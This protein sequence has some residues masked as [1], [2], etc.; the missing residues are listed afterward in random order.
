MISVKTNILA[1][2]FNYQEISQLQ[3]EISKH[4]L[5]FNFDFAISVR[6][7]WFSH[8]LVD[9]D[10]ILVDLTSSEKET[11]DVLQEIYKYGDGIS[12]IVIVN[13][14]ELSKISNSFSINPHHFIVKD[15]NYVVKVVSLIKKGADD[16]K[17]SKESDV[18]RNRRMHPLFQTFMNAVHDRVMII[19]MDYRIKV[20]N[21]AVLEKYHCSVYEIVGKKCYEFAYNYDKPC[22]TRNLPCP[23]IQI[24]SKGQSC[25]VMH[26]FIKPDNNN[27][28]LL[29]ISAF[30]L[31]NEFNSTIEIL[32]AVHEENLN[33]KMNAFDHRILTKLI[34]GISE[35]IVF[36]NSQ[37]KVV[38]VNQAAKRLL[39][40][41]SDNWAGMSI[42]EMP[43]G[44]GH[45]W[46][47]YI[48]QNLNSNFIISSPVKIQLKD[49]WLLLRYMPLTDSQNDYLGGFL[50]ITD[51]SLNQTFTET[52][53]GIDPDILSISKFFS[54]KIIAEG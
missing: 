35:G 21:Q 42:F 13:A 15:E 51:L 44:E 52:Q 7:S 6:D 33:Q 41:E 37:H 48:I 40:I 49:K 11:V 43:L 23:L 32:V 24:S 47:T 38:L 25:R 34:D 54:R 3:N 46:L 39:E 22:P 2:G 26:S 16:G 53:K 45:E 27:N 18:I 5:K 8:N 14:N 4:F 30:P 1:I 50:Y 12:I 17:E 19:G 10:S 29:A 36:C 20:V 9:Y 28:K 31:T